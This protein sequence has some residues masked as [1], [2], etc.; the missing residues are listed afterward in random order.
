M[1]PETASAGGRAK[2]PLF[3]RRG[4]L[5]SNI[6]LRARCR[7]NRFGVT[8]CIGDDLHARHRLNVKLCGLAEGYGG[9]EAY[10][11]RHCS[12]VDFQG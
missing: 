1:K 8:A 6:Y 3:N 9:G 12:A 2:L 4:I 5:K 10:R 7:K 11:S